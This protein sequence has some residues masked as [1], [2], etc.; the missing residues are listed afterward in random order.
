M[1]TLLYIFLVAFVLAASNV[2]LLAAA[3]TSTRQ[4]LNNDS[5]HRYAIAAL[6]RRD[7]P[8]Y[9][10]NNDA[11]PTSTGTTSHETHDCKNYDGSTYAKKKTI[12]S[13]AILEL[14]R[15]SSLIHVCI[16]YCIPA[17]V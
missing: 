15:S 10:D 12:D 1:K 9:W 16:C 3:P 8:Q 7:L 13:T 4:N 11:S 17:N 6:R 5:I 14:R 2:V